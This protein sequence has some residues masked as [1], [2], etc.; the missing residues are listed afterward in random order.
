MH[1]EVETRFAFNSKD[2]IFFV[3]PQLKKF[4]FTKIK[5]QTKLFNKNIFLKDNQ[6]RYSEIIVEDKKLVYLGYK[7]NDIGSFCNIRQEIDEEITDI[8]KFIRKSEI[9][10]NILRL[11]AKEN[12]KK[13][14]NLYSLMG[15]LK[16]FNFQ[17]FL[18]FEGESEVL[19]IGFN[20]FVKD[21]DGFQINKEYLRCALKKLKF[22][23][24]IMYCEKLVFPLLLELELIS[25]NKKMAFIYEKI[26]KEITQYYKLNNLYIKKEPPTILYEQTHNSYE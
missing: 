18:S 23:I 10:R 1:F 5:W 6:L 7:G 24:K 22:N 3:F 12:I 9:L 17:E 4:N 21:M 19:S 25:K 16:T 26:I 20:D 14:K 15:L 13:I 11:P 2:D 8:K